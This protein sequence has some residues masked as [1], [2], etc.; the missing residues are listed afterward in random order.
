MCLSYVES[1]LFL[2]IKCEQTMNTKEVIKN[3]EKTG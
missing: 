2:Q 1:M 3:S